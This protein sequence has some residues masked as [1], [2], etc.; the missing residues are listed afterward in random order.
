V[1]LED[2]T[3]TWAQMAAME[4]AKAAKAFAVADGG[5]GGRGRGASYFVYSDDDE[6]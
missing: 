1:D 3:E 2:H 5:R 4:E 6:A